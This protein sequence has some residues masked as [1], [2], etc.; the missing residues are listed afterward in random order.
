MAAVVNIRHNE[1]KKNG[2]KNFAEWYAMPYTLYVGRRNK[3]L[4][5]PNSKWSNPFKLKDYSRE[6]S[7]ILYERYV[8]ST[9][10]LIEN[11]KEIENKELGCWCH[12]ENCHA[13]ILIKL[14]NEKLSDD[15]MTF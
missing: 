1:L 14:L 13:D 9:P 5:I 15:L 12:P 2:F 8:R 11:I 10:H 4:G 7:L 3:T 6:T